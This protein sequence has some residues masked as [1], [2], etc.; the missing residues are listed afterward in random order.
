MFWFLSLFF[1]MLGMHVADVWYSMIS[2]ISFRIFI[3]ESVFICYRYGIVF[4][5]FSFKYTGIFSTPVV[6]YVNYPLT[7]PTANPL[8]LLA[9]CFSSCKFSI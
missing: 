3:K 2:T 5:G 4:I 9:R 6:S 7:I 8:I 1:L